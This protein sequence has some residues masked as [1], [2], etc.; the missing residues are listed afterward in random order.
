MHALRHVHRLVVPGGTL[1]DVHPTTLER[2]E[3]GGRALGVIEDP[4]WLDVDLPNAERRLRELT[5]EGLFTLEAEAEFDLLQHFDTA[6]D[7]IDARRDLLEEQPE[8][9][10]DIR[11]AAP[12]LVNREHYVLRRLRVNPSR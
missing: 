9:V 4:E 2:V 12:P 8:L 6:D 10:R 1:V 11:A 7:L 3:A 5:G